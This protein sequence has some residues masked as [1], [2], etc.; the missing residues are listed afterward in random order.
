MTNGPQ[1]AAADDECSPQPAS[2][3]V[4][5]LAIMIAD[6]SDGEVSSE[7]ALAGDCSFTALG[8]TSLAQVRLVDA[9][10][11]EFRVDIDPDSD[12]FFSGTVL[13]LAEYLVEQGV[14]L[15]PLS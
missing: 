1:R 5:V 13:D 15:S 4:E 11:Y 10:E 9:I 8:L 6:A 14:E 12:L 7:Q 3:L 2:Q